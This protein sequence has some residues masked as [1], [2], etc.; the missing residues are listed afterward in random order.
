MNI[1]TKIMIGAILVAAFAVAVVFRGTVSALLTF[2]SSDAPPQP[3][4]AEPFVV[5][6]ESKSLSEP[7]VNPI[8]PPAPK[9]SK[10]PASR[11]AAYAGRDPGEIRPV[12]EEVKLFTDAQ[13]EQ[14][15]AAVAMHAR[16]VVAD[17]G[18]FNGWIQIGILKK[19][20]GDFEGARDAWEYAGVIE[21]ANSLSFANL[22]ELYWRYLHEY[23]K[24]EQNL[25]LSIAHKP[26][27]LQT[28]ATL[29]ELYHYSMAE[30]KDQAPQVLLDGI[31]ANPGG[32]ETLMRRLAYL[33]EQRHEYANALEWWEKTLVLHPE[34]QEIK[35]K[36]DLLR[37]KIGK[38]GLP[39]DLPAST[40]AQAG[41]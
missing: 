24:A 18:Y 36:I 15:Y 30:K 17:P 39:A 38:T 27:D 23:G 16:A 37:A 26:N 32:S 1:K 13:K 33:Y 12:P 22:G 2:G 28:Y 25:K 21:P 41:Q 20:I 29:A 3:A 4:P 8:A 34:D 5:G 9:I 7:A 6:S 10:P 19:T 35:I 31:A 14:L 11:L 40:M